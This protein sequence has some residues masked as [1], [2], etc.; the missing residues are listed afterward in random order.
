[1]APTEKHW[2]GLRGSELCHL[3]EANPPPPC[4]TTYPTPALK[5]RPGAAPQQLQEEQ[6]CSAVPSQVTRCT[7][8]LL[9]ASTN[10][11]GLKNSGDGQN[12]RYLNP[13]RTRHSQK[14]FQC[15]EIHTHTHTHTS[16]NTMGKIFAWDQRKK[17]NNSSARY[18]GSRSSKLRSWF[19]LFWC[20]QNNLAVLKGQAT[21]AWYWTTV[22]KAIA[23]R[24]QIEQLKHIAGVALLTSG[25]PPKPG[26]HPKIKNW[27]PA[28]NGCWSW[29][30]VTLLKKH[31]INL[32][33][34]IRTIIG[35]N[36]ENACSHSGW[37]KKRRG[38]KREIS[39][40]KSAYKQGC[41][42]PLSYPEPP[43]IERISI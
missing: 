26:I 24:E 2:S 28:M 7:F 17:N 3:P 11:N 22:S 13:V 8:P 1:M 32:Q 12:I 15:Y 30:F 35:I 27:Q 43:L 18:Q 5:L 36:Q 40:S 33:P 23:S 6:L 10:I 29:L 16:P 19:M 9:A 34:C 25:D 20:M 37:K 31:N 42:F 41:Y 21:W 14:Y 38:G 39:K 4:R